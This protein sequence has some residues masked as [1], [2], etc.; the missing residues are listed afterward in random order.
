M[1]LLHAQRDVKTEM[2][3]VEHLLPALLKDKEGIAAQILVR[4]WG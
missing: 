3:D 2:V 1:A 4:L